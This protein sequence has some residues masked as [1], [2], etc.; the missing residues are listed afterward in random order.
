LGHQS[1]YLGRARASADSGGQEAALRRKEQD[2]PLAKLKARENLERIIAM[3]EELHLKAMSRP[4][5][6]EETK[7]SMKR[8]FEAYIAQLRSQR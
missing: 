4:E 7:A 5:Y 3:H 2:D 6:S 1:G 8:G